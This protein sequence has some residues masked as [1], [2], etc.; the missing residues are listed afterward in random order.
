[1][2]SSVLAVVFMAAAALATSALA[3]P[4][5]ATSSSAPSRRIDVAPSCAPLPDKGQ[6]RPASGAA[7]PNAA[8]PQG[9]AKDQRTAKDSDDD[10]NDDKDFPPLKPGQSLH[11]IAF[12]IEG[13]KHIDENAL[14]ATLPEHVGDPISEAQ[15]KANTEKIKK[16]LTARHVH[17]ADIT[18]GML[19]REGPDHCVRVIWG[20]QHID[21]FS[22]LPYQGYWKFGGQTFSGNKA[23]SNE[24]LEKAVDLKLGD[25][26]R[27]GDISDGITGIQ[28]AYDKI[29]PGQTVK[30]KGKL[31]LTLKPERL[32][33]FEWQIEEPPAK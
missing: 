13:S 8:H 28:Q 21:A 32:A 19:Q 12:S 10:D 31:K 14:I 7:A 9:S 15:I 30:V 27:E 17:F 24:Q 16:A 2:R 18:I 3:T 1:M 4:P 5:P 20:I 11:L 25:L 26:V 33:N 22:Q 6:V 23:L 29:F